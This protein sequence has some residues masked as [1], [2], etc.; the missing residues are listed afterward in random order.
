MGFGMRDAVTGSD[1]YLVRLHEQ[2][3]S[4]RLQAR[5]GG[6]NTNLVDFNSQTFGQ[7]LAVRTVVD[8]ND[9]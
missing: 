5:I 7:A 9:D 2:S 8:L 6:T 1:F 3:S 4:L